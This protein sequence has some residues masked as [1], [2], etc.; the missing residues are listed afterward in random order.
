MIFISRYEDWFWKV[1]LGKCYFRLGM[2]RD[3]EA[4]FKSAIKQ[5]P[6]IS[7]FLQ[8]GKIY[9][10]LD[11]PLAALEVYRTGLDNFAG[12]VNLLVGVAR[13]QEALGN[14]SLSAKYYK[15]VLTEDSTHVEA[16]ACIGM[17]HFYSDQ[18]E[19]SLRYYRRL[20]QMGIAT[21]ELYNNLGLCCFYAQQ[22]DMA[23]TCLQRALHVAD[24][25]ML[26]EVWYNVG[27]L[28]LGIGDVNLAYQCFKLALT[29]NNDHAESYNNIGV[30]E[31][32]KGRVE[33]AR[34]FFQTA[35]SL[36]PNMWECHY[37]FAVLS[38]KVGDLQSSYVLVQKSL[39]NFPRHADSKDL[40]AQ[41]ARHFQHL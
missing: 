11:Q 18:P 19:L 6:M 1:A 3:A 41:L 38:E 20:L 22:Y 15:N 10:R 4:Q 27:H 29:T 25:E 32:R 28:S 23:I 21:A 2:M 5:Q 37:N 33:Q 14:L 39:E 30:L 31:M 36:S 26:A 34:A 17:N 12:D 9:L 13:I 8:L 16:I 7:T 35:A 40:L 24:K